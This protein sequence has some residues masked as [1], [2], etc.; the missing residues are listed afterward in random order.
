MRR[1]LLPPLAAMIL[2][3]AACLT[4]PAGAADTVLQHPIVPGFERF[5]ANTAADRVAGGRLLL[6][7]L[8]CVACHTVKDAAQ[9]SILPKPPQVYCHGSFEVHGYMGR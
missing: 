7:E 6:G 1:N 9:L 5:Y 2:C 3:A 4:A 8:N